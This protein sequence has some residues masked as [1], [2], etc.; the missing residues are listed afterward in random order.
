MTSF[1]K[2]NFKRCNKMKCE[3][4]WT[5]TTEGTTIKGEHLHLYECLKCGIL[6]YGVEEMEQDE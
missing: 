3:H 5:T 4:T 2:I 6:D 1:V